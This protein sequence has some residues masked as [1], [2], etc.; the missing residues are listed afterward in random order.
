MHP[1]K[2]SSDVCSSFGCFTSPG[3]QV[4]FGVVAGRLPGASG[5]LRGAPRAAESSEVAAGRFPGASCAGQA[6]Q[7]SAVRLRGADGEHLFENAEAN[8]RAYRSR[9]AGL[10]RTPSICACSIMASGV[11]SGEMEDTEG[12]IE[13]RSARGTVQALNMGWVDPG[14]ERLISLRGLPPETR[15]ARTSG[16]R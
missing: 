13:R 11:G 7:D 8:L 3:F 10:A 6:S 14:R 5:R 1:A 4:A 2:L 16:C 12:K 9:G 15:E